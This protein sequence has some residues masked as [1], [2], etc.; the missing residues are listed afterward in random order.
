MKDRWIGQ[1]TVHR[2]GHDVV[3]EF[4]GGTPEIGDLLRSARQ[5]R[6]ISLRELA[7]RSG[8]SAGTI[9]RI[10]AGEVQQPGVS[11]LEA[12][13][14][15]FGRPL[16][17]LL[18]ITG[19]IDRNEFDR[20]VAS[21]EEAFGALEFADLD[22]VGDEDAASIVWEHGDAELMASRIGGEP[23][24]KRHEGLEE[25]AAAWPAL[26]PDRRR[27]VLAFV[28]DQEVLSTLDRMPSPPGRYG[29]EV[30]LTERGSDDA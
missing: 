2:D 10:Q 28:A 24:A 30:T 18:L 4:E 7:R 27:L 19:H 5:Q 3:E 20:R 21:L 16:E 14:D 25:I 1:R 26:S 9:S 17:P 12:I 6:G 23:W 22:A 29:L 11:T 8:I 15:A 13:A